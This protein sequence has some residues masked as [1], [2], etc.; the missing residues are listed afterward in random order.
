[1]G[2]SQSSDERFKEIGFLLISASNQL[3]GQVQISPN[4]S[5]MRLHH[6]GTP[7]AASPS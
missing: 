3:I 4:L 6:A 7:A 5:L 1:V 2:E